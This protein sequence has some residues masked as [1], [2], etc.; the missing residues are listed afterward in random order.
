MAS[1]HPCR[2]PLDH[3]RGQARVPLSIQL[4]SDIRD[5]FE[6]RGT[7]RLASASIIAELIADEHKPWLDF[8]KSQKP[9]TQNKLAFLLKPYGIFPHTVRI[10]SESTPKGYDLE[11]FED[12][13]SR[14]LEP[15]K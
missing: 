9:I 5:I 14:Y 2:R 1:P 15:K 13:F 3:E 12:T 7:D 8:G 10:S 11:D 4:L 6:L